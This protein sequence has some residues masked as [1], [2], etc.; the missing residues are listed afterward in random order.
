MRCRAA[1]DANSSPP[2]STIAAVAL[3]YSNL[4]A[5]ARTCRAARMDLRRARQSRHVFRCRRSSPSWSA[6]ASPSASATSGGASL[7]HSMPLSIGEPLSEC[8]SALGKTAVYLCMTS[9]SNDRAP[10]SSAARC[11]IC[12]P[13]IQDTATAWR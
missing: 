4:G 13:A 7:A 8:P 12:E 1:S 3:A 5:L 6:D 10:E 9:R 2:W 11:R